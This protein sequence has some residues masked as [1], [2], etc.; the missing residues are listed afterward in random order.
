MKKLSII[1]NEK[2]QTATEFA[3]LLP[4]ILLIMLSVIDMGRFAVAISETTNCATDIARQLDANPN[5]SQTEVLQY[6]HSAH[7]ELVGDL[8]ITLTNGGQTE[9][10]SQY[11]IWNQDEQQF[12]SRISKYTTDKTYVTVTYKDKWISPGAMSFSGITT[13]DSTH[14]TVAKSSVATNDTTIET[15]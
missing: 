5:M 10:D 7:P 15:W 11:K 8:N 6:A 1:S 9:T 13:G 2:G 12:K 14:F 4:I 3:L